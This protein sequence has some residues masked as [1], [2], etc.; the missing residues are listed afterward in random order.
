MVPSGENLSR[1]RKLASWLAVTTLAI[2]V[3]FIGLTAAQAQTYSEIYHFTSADGGPLTSTL[4]IDRGGKLY[5]TTEYGQYGTCGWAGMVYQLKPEGSGWVLNP[6]HC[7]TAPLGGDD[8][9]FPIDYGGLTFGP[10]GNIY[11]TTDEGGI[12]NGTDSLGTVF[13][14]TPPLTVCVT[15]LC[16]WESTVLY[17]FGTNNPDGVFPQGNVVFDAAGNMY[18]TTEFGGHGDGGAFKMTYANG[19]WTENLIY[20]FIDG[21]EAQAG[22]IVDSAGNL[23]GTLPYGGLGYGIVFQLTPGQSG[24]TQNVI[25]RFTNG[26]DGE[27]PF[28]G[29]AMDSAGNL[30]GAT[31]LGGADYGGVIY[32]LS[33][34]GSGWTFSLLN[35]LYGGGGPLSALTMDAAGNLYGT[36]QSDGE[37]GLGNIFEL[38]PGQSGW[39]YTD[40]HSYADSDDGQR[41][42]AGVTIAPDGTL[43]GVG[44][45][46]AWKITR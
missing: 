18:G 46:V 13:K 4:L 24:W 31:S 17:K 33:P 19:V 8:G 23:Y 5:G 32:E 41:P 3:L 27:T 30:Y 22:L 28:A 42:Y 21:A 10:D 37:Y 36:T 20:A 9:A 14:L 26:A 40:L 7:F 2:A 25:Y 29:L 45:S 12:N 1:G 15:T 6:L 38:S 44:G 39:T 43:Y 16:P 35:S 11:G 34:S